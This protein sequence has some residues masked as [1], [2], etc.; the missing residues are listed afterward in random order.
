MQDPDNRVN[1]MVNLGGGSAGS[2]R[3][4]DLKWLI[5]DVIPVIEAHDSLGGHNG[6]FCHVYV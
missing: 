5:G 1:A 3:K 4:V 6:A 2:T